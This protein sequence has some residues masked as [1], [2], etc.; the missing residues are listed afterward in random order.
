MVQCNHCPKLQSTSV[1]PNDDLKT[2]STNTADQLTTHLISPNST[3]S[4]NIF[5]LMITPL[6]TSHLF[7]QNSLNLMKTVYEKLEKHTSSGEVILLNHQVWIRKMKCN[8]S[9]ISSS[10]IY[11]FYF[12]I[13]NF[14]QIT[15]ST[16]LVFMYFSGSLVFFLNFQ[17]LVSYC[18]LFF[19]SNCNLLA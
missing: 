14:F 15:T 12:Y 7:H 6:K 10:C 13:S 11:L 3:Q 5:L 4:Q 17:L 19:I 18:T 2:V 1:K 8:T 9:L 16:V